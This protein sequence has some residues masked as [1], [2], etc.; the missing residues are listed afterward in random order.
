MKV[1]MFYGQF[2]EGGTLVKKGD[3]KVPLETELNEFLAH[4]KEYD[5]RV[6]EILQTE[7]QDGITISVWYFK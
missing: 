3:K 5:I 2:L 6:R 1:K 7:T 4:L